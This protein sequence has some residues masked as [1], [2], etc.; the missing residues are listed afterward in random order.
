MDILVIFFIFL[1]VRQLGQFPV[2]LIHNRPE[3][4]I[5]QR[6][7]FAGIGFKLLNSRAYFNGQSVEF[8]MAQ[9]MNSRGFLEIMKAL[10]PSL[11][12]SDSLFINQQPITTSEM[13]TTASK[14]ATTSSL[15]V[16]VQ[17]P[18]SFVASSVM[19]FAVQVFWNMN[20]VTVQ[21]IMATR[22]RTDTRILSTDELEIGLLND[23][24]VENVN[25]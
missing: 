10:S 7:F 13:P 22:E 12:S 18:L 20:M 2:N 25:S 21:N 8:P 5:Y 3:F 24:E 4:K 17:V 9:R 15:I 14:H 1:K 6:G 16:E 19:L 11:A 23:R